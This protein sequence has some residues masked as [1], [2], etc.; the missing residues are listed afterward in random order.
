MEKLLEL[1]DYYPINLA[2]VLLEYDRYFNLPGIE[3]ERERIIDSIE[4]INNPE[5]PYTL[6]FF[7]LNHLPICIVGMLKI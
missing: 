2:T 7:K 3:Y 4:I 6:R 1:K 5:L